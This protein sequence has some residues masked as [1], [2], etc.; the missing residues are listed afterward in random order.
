[1]ANYFKNYFS[2]IFKNVKKSELIYWWILR[3]L[4][5]YALID[6]LVNGKDYSGS[7]PPAQ[8]CANLVGMFAYEIIQFFPEKSKLRLFSPRFQNITALGFL[9]GSFGGAY[10]NLYYSLPMYDKILHATGTAEGVYIGYEYVCATQ[11]KLKKTCPHQ[12]ASL[13]S[14]GF[15]FVLANFWELFEFVYDQFFGGD[16]QHWNLQNALAEAGGKIE[17]IFCMFPFSDMELFAQ[18]FPLMDTMC[19]IVMN[20][21][22]GFIMFA[23]LRFFPYRHR[24]KND[25]NA[26][27]EARQ[28]AEKE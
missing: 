14:L 9:L 20:F 18:R 23:V 16:A 26:L 21:I 13:C 11:L 5:I 22:G 12:I 6:T 4:M 17:N 28:T 1:M 7:N 3:G 24:G 8:I 27:I 25:I 10:L 19:D 15:G 2:R